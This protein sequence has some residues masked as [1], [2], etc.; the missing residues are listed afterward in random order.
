VFELDRIGDQG[1]GLVFNLS[2]KA[3]YIYI[4]NNNNNEFKNILTNKS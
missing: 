4:Y 3:I 1:M 2:C